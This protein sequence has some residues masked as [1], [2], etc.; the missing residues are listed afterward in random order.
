MPLSKTPELS[1]LRDRANT[2]ESVLQKLWLGRTLPFSEGRAL[3]CRC[4]SLVSAFLRAL[5]RQDEGLR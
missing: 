3:H 5:Q 4:P 1:K 2:A